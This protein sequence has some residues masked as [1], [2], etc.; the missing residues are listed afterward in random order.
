MDAVL[1]DPALIDSL[2]IEVPNTVPELLGQTLLLTS[3]PAPVQAPTPAPTPDLEPDPAPVS[4]PETAPVHDED[5]SKFTGSD[6]V[7]FGLVTAATLV[8][9]GVVFM[10]GWLIY[11]LV[12]SIFGAVATGVAVGAGALPLLAVLLVVFMFC[13]GRG[14]GGAVSAASDVGRGAGGAFGVVG[15]VVAATATVT[16]PLRRGRS[17][18]GTG[19]PVAITQAAR[20]S[21]MGRL[22]G[23]SAR[24]DAARS[25]TTAPSTSAPARRGVVA[26]LATGTAAAPRRGVTGAVGRMA[27]GAPAAAP[28]A[29]PTTMP[30]RSGL[31]ARAFGAGSVAVN[32]H[33]ERVQGRT[34]RLL[35]GPSSPAAQLEAMIAGRRHDGALGWLRDRSRGLSGRPDPLAHSSDIPIEFMVTMESLTKRWVDRMRA[36]RPKDQVHGVWMDDSMGYCRFCAVGFLWDEFDHDRWF[37]HSRSRAF[38]GFKRWYHRDADRLFKQFGHKFLWY[39]SDQY[40][41]GVCDGGVGWSLAQ[42]ADFVEATILKGE[43]F[44][45]K[46]A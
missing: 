46:S 30:R 14:S 18:R 23:T 2:K 43:G 38:G 3:A 33:G 10:V 44:D 40:E 7:F 16:S 8:G 4:L 45:A 25:M 28:V 42:C 9:A 29:R 24:S 12:T 1:A 27:F 37:V 35:Y 26:R 41:N 39:I 15:S 22:F 5:Y 20:P 31:A 34:A 21:A 32:A 36:A 6:Y 13:R 19:S 11:A 17:R